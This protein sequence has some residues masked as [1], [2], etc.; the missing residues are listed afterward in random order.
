MRT[1]EFLG[2]DNAAVRCWTPSIA[3]ATGCATAS[4]CRVTLQCLRP[5]GTHDP[6]KPLNEHSI[7]VCGP[8]LAPYVRSSCLV[9]GRELRGPEGINST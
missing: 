2:F 6:R 4:R 3:T 9:A 7:A 1:D 5:H 8:D